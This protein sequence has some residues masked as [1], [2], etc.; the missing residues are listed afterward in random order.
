MLMVLNNE[1]VK[2]D[3]DVGRAFPPALLLAASSPKLGVI[4]NKQ[5]AQVSPDNKRPQRTGMYPREKYIDIVQ[6]AKIM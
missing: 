5:Q 1:Q 2:R 6:E 3:Y 4:N